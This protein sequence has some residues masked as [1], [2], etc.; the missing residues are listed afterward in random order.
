MVVNSGPVITVAAT[1]LEREGNFSESLIQPID[2]TTGMPFPNNNTIPQG[3]LDQN[4]LL[5]LATY[6]PQPTPNYNLDNLY[7]FI[8]QAP[9]YTR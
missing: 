5:L 8:S 3:R 1:A 4:A 6:F 7:N 9:N 2:P